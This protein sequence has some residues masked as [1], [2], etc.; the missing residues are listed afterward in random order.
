MRIHSFFLAA[1]MPAIALSQ[2]SSP[3]AVRPMTF[4]DRQY[5]RDV[6]S[7]TPSPDGKW[8]LYTLS[9]PDWN[10]A[11]RQTDI[12]LVSVKD[13]LPSTKQMTFTKDKNETS[14]HWSRDGKFFVFLSNRD[15]ASAPSAGGTGTGGANLTSQNQIYVMRPDGGEA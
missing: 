4:L 11:R 6:G 14:P 8:L 9:T 10:Q 12:Y 1:L 15:A 5:Q 3:D 7:P 13:G 2:K